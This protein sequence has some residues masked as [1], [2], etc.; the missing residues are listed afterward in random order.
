MIDRLIFGL[1]RRRRDAVELA[2]RSKREIVACRRCPR[3]VAWR[4]EVARVK[5]AV[6][7]RSRTTGAGPLPGFGDPAA[8]VR[9]PRAGAGG[10]RRQ[11]HRAHVHRR[12]LRR[13]AVRGAV[14][15]RARQPADLGGA[16]RRPAAARTAGSRPPSAARRR[17]TSRRR[18]SATPACRTSR[19]S[20]RCWRG[21]RVI[22]CLG[23][24]AWDAALR[25]ARAPVRARGR[26]SGTAPR[27]TCGGYTLLGCYHPSQQNTFTGRL[28]EPMLD[29]SSRGRRG[30]AWDIRD[31]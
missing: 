12:P 8:S 2:R 7:R 5:R 28:T 27:R 19:A 1:L 17:P 26:G 24:F 4:E 29:A 25:I 22:V 18:S 16:R 11:P 6:V 15:G 23:A 3:L 13:L 9:R 20:W 10:A 31:V 30:R 21:A 14:A